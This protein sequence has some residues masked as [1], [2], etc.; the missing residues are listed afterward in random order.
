M[1]E[2]L[3]H[4]LTNYRASSFIR[5]PQN[6]RKEKHKVY[7]VVSWTFNHPPLNHQSVRGQ[8]P[9]FASLKENQYYLGKYIKTIPDRDFAVMFKLDD[10]RNLPSFLTQV[11]GIFQM[12][13]SD[14]ETYK[15]DYA[16][17]RK[18]FTNSA[19]FM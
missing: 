12:Y 4:I 8:H 19:F 2:F 9:L 1:Q 11:D 3:Q 7:V 6:P 18:K 16:N 17:S 14:V 10:E 5:S 15:Y 13:S